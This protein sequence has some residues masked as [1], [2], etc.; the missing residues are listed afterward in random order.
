M[1]VESLNWLMKG[2]VAIQ[3]QVKRDLL[4]LE[5]S[6]LRERI[7]SEG[8]GARFLSLRRDDGHWGRAYY[9]PKWTSTHY[10]LLD[11]KN[12]AISPQLGSVGQTIELVLKNETGADGGINPSATIQQSD[13]CMTGMF[14]NVASYFRADEGQLRSII[15]F[16]LSQQLADGGFNCQFNRSG[17]VHSSLHSTLSV[18]EGIAE[19][20]AGGYVY[21]LKELQKVE[22][23]GREFILRHRLFRSDHP[24]RAT[25]SAWRRRSRWCSRIGGRTRGGR[26]RPDTPDKPILK[27]KRSDSR[28]AGT[29]CGLCACSS[30]LVL[31]RCFRLLGSA[32]DIV[33]LVSIIGGQ[34]GIMDEY[35]VLVMF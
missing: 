13:V 4:D 3:Y 19:Y 25:I 27:W 34:M 8:W 7:A 26:Y 15:D 23:E 24:E 30:I 2:D 33:E 21:R 35:L 20:A 10:T 16:I 18:I 31:D 5:Q 22:E 28:A 11:L 32:E 9:Q 12:L 6:T 29:R 14:L 17:A 1:N